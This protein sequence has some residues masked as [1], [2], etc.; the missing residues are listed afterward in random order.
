MAV[1]EFL[2]SPLPISPV[3]GAV[4]ALVLAF[5][6]KKDAFNLQDHG[7]RISPWVWAICTFLLVAVTVPVYVVMRYTIW[8]T[9]VARAGGNDP[10]NESNPQ[11]RCECGETIAVRTSMAGLTVACSCGRSVP[12]PS[13]GELNKL[14]RE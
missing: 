10:Q 4:L 3:V 11:L 8:K 2:N 12:V 7:A 1:L 9:A 6:V 13:F 5:I 14:R